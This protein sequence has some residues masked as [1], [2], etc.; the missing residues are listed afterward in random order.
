LPEIKK[1]D[2]IIV[3]SGAGGATAARVLTDR[4]FNVVVLER[5]GPSNAEDFIPL[6]ELHFLDHKALIPSRTTDPMMYVDT[7]RPDAKPEPTERWWI[8]HMVGG[9]TNQWEANLPRYTE[10]DFAVTRYL[11]DVPSDVS[12][13]DWPWTYQQF[14]PWFERA[15]WDWGVS[16]KARQ[17]PAQEPMRADYDYPMPPIREH[18]SSPF[19]RFIFNKAGM[20]PYRSPRGINSRTNDSRPGCP[21]CGFCQGFGCASNCRS[22]AADTVLRK[23]LATGRCDLRTGHNVMRLLFER[24]DQNGRGHRAVGVEYVTSPNG[25]RKTLTAPIVIVS[26][27]AI[28]SARLYLLS[29][30]PNSNGLAGRY[31]TYHTKGD[32]EF[33]FPNQPFWGSMDPTYPYQPSTSL[34]SLQLRDLYVVKDD[35]NAPVSKGGKFSIYDP[36]TI[37]PPLKALYRTGMPGKSSRL[38]GRHLQDRLVELRE[39]GGVSFSFTGETMSMADNRVELA[40]GKEGRPEKLDPYGQPV[41]LTYYRHHPYDIALSSYALNRVANIVGNAGGEIRVN[42]PQTVANPGYGHNHGTLRAGADPDTSV[43]D[44][45]C[46]SHQVQGLY[47]IDAAFMPTAGASNPS[48]TMIANAYRVCSGMTKPTMNA[49]GGSAG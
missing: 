37:N 2:A 39:N 4:G 46:Q 12:M 24:D 15:E 29:E 3:G 1:P 16:G 33:T 14:Q 49:G 35:P 44:P 43:L 17:S 20:Y 30:L 9:S 47:V 32:L 23:A 36:I 18:G 10:E 5:G 48:L 7:S 22:G 27:Q 6:D 28:E 45:N 42:K 38:W 31:L 25:D 26:I 19:L 40:D 11:K 21:F 41:A 13:V 8:T 34:G